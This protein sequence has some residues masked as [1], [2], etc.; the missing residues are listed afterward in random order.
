[1][2]LEFRLLLTDRVRFFLPFSQFKGKNMRTI[3]REFCIE[4]KYE[5]ARTS[6]LCK[7]HLVLHIIK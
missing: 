3:S 1:M 6:Y 2:S 7:I 5:N 4:L